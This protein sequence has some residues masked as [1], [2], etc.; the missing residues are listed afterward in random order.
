MSGYLP[1]YS[2]MAYV[3]MMWLYRPIMAKSSL[4]EKDSPKETLFEQVIARHGATHR[5]IPFGACTYNSMVEA[6]HRLIETECY[7][8]MYRPTHQGFFH[9]VT[10]YQRHFNL[11]RVNTYRGANSLALFIEK[12]PHVHVD[13]LILKPII[14]DTLLTRERYRTWRTWQNRVP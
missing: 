9:D 13:A 11:E 12:A 14:V 1:I 3:C 6:S 2:I 4:H 8:D 10:Q 5:R 7:D